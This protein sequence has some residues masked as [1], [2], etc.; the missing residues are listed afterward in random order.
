MIYIPFVP[1]TVVL[2]LLWIAARAV[3]WLRNRKIDWK[4]EAQLLLVYTCIM[5]VARVTFFPFAKVDGQ[6]QP[7]EFD[8]ANIFPFRINLV[9][10]VH[11]FEYES[12]RDAIINFV[13]NVTMF[14]PMGIVWPIVYKELN[15]HAKV[16]AAGVAFPLII[17]I[18]QLPFY[19]RLSDIDDIILNSAGFL[20][21]YGIYLLTKLIARRISAAKHA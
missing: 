5:V 17:E 2:T 14:I 19:A 10:F 15:T 3:V 9:P 6:V 21:G 7:L 18:I 13:G 1:T 4:R 12:R 16:I 8:T 20:I 11:L